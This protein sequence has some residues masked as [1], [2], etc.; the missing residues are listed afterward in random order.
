MDLLG[1]DVK[2]LEWYQMALRAIFVFIFALILIR[3]A[4]MRTFGSKSAFD[5]V[6]SITLGAILSKAIV[7]H[8]PFFA[9]LI[10]AATLALTHRLI[11]FLSYRNFFINKFT[12]GDAIPLFKNNKK[13]KHNMRTYCI[14][15]KELIQALHKENIDDF[16]MVKTIWFEAN[17]KI[18]VVKKSA[19]NILV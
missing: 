1:L 19:Q 10:A 11:A 12:Q 2:E 7:G 6:L 5:I 4:G 9:C 16:D 13:L 17:G 14:T 8:Y 3:I 18:T 15:D